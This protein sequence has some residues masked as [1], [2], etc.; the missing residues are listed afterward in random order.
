MSHKSPLPYQGLEFEIRSHK[1]P[2]PTLVFRFCCT[3]DEDGKRE[4]K[5][6]NPIERCLLNPPLKGGQRVP[7][8]VELNIV[9]TIHVGEGQNAQVVAVRVNNISGD[10]SS[11]RAE[12]SRQ[13]KWSLLNPFRCV[14]KHYTHE[15][16]AYSAVKPAGYKDPNVLR[17]VHRLFPREP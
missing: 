16:A 9:D 17:L 1:P 8:I 5:E 7:F 15:A 3:D 11:H 12:E 4:R 6:L 10:T 2:P 13:Q 14:D